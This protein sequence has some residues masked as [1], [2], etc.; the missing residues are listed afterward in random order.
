MKVAKLAVAFL[1]FASMMGCSES[2]ALKKA[3]ADAEA[4]RAESAKA[5]AEAEAAKAELALLRKTLLAQPKGEPDYN[6]IMAVGKR[7][8]ILL[9][10]NDPVVV[11]DDLTSLAYQK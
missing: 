3:K 6:Q 4:A 8:V 11:Y 9:R 5:K 1:G 7:F 10:D 2:D